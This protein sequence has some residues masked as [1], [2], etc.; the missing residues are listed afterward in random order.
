[1]MTMICGHKN[2]LILSVKIFN[3]N[4]PFDDSQKKE[5][6]ASEKKKNNKNRIRIG[7]H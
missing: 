5:K 4:I 6:M 1:M 3:S 7:K 2:L